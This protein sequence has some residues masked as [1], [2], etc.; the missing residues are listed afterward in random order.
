M[1]VATELG[2]RRIKTNESTCQIKQ[3]LVPGIETVVC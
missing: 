1:L 3:D 2:E